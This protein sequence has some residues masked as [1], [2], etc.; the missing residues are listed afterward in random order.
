[1][2][3]FPN[4]YSWTFNFVIFLILESFKRDLSK[5]WYICP[6]VFSLWTGSQQGR[7]KIRRASE[8]ES[9]RRDPASEASAH[10]LLTRP[11]SAHPVRPRLH[12]ALS[13]GSLF[14]GYTVLQ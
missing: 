5:F 14:A 4:K 2:G 1:M 8:W 6:T 3:Y 10:S 12:S 13:N 9:E 11:L 7:E